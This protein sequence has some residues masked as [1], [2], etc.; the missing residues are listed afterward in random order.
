M[1]FM[2]DRQRGQLQEFD[3]HAAA[4]ATGRTAYSAATGSPQPLKMSAQA[5]SLKRAREDFE[6]GGRARRG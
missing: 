5:V 3:V 6:R 2:V 4:I 1:R